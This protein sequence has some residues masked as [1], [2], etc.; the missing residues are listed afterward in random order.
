MATI[1]KKIMDILYPYKLVFDPRESNS[2]IEDNITYKGYLTY[3]RIG[4][5]DTNGFLA[6]L[7]F[8]QLEV[9]IKTSF[10][11]NNSP[12]PPSRAPRRILYCDWQRGSQLII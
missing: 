10:P 3:R 2:F 6:L 4:D 8:N 7:I 12:P 1:N 5:A 9:I 11:N